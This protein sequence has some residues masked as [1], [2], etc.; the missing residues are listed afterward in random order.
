MLLDF[1]AN[2]KKKKDNNSKLRIEAEVC[3][4]AH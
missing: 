2:G 4:K 1:T 3:M